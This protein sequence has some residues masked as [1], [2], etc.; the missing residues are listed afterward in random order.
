MDRRI[1]LAG[2]LGLAAS[3]ATSF[4][5]S[6]KNT[7]HGQKKKG[8]KKARNKDKNKKPLTL[9]YRS[10]SSVAQV[11][12]ILGPLSE[13]MGH[14]DTHEGLSLDE[15]EA[16]MNQGVRLVILC[17][18]QSSLAIRA[19]SRAGIDARL[20]NPLTNEP[21]QNNAAFGHTSMEVRV[22]DRWQVFD[23]TGNAQLVDS[24]GVGLDVSTACQT[25]PLLYRS[26][27]FDPLTTTPNSALNDL[28]AYYEWVFQIPIIRS[29]D[30]WWRFHDARNRDRIES[31]DHSWHWATGKEW[32][33][34]QR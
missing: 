21:W 25:R 19:L 17:G 5:K 9:T 20:I 16:L 15:L 6:R 10:A 4:A 24:Q 8:K 11:D 26:F 33:R 31:I 12:A 29:D 2:S 34:L 32:E 14:G 7:R 3:P 13:K 23:M 28:Q 18:N 30:L 1:L 27:A 22:E